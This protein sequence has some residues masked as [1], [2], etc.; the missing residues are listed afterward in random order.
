MARVKFEH[1]SKH[2]GTNT[3]L[4]DISLSV[5][6]GE[7]LVLV[8]P[9]GCGKS[10]MLRMLA[11]LEETVE[12]AISIGDKM[13]NGFPPRERGIAMVF[14]DYA[15]YPHMTVEENMSF[16]LRLRNMKKSEIDERVM[17]AADILRIKPL[18]ARTPKQL[19]GGQRQR[20]AIGR[21]IVRK[22]EV[23]LFDEPLSNLDAKLREEMRVEIT[24]LHQRLKTTIIYVTHDQVEAMTMADRI[25][26]LDKGHVQQVGAP[27]EIYSRPVNTFV[28]GFIGSPAMNFIDGVLE[29]TGLGLTFSSDSAR[30]ALQLSNSCVHIAS[31][32]K[33]PVVLGVRP[34]SIYLQNAAPHARV[35]VE[36]VELLGHRKY[37][38]L[39]AGEQDILASVPASCPLKHGET[40]NISFELSDIHLFDKNTGN[41]L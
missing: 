22:P 4:N 13:V 14:Q 9:S 11:G 39:R 25:A 36:V 38:H 6:D 30:I 1:I 15:L 32:E 5:A 37:L 29:E 23:F 26:V 24:A 28:A 35:V 34:E 19:S 2:F 3:V 16:G 27:E 18:L 21:A 7:F 41:R 12:G 20:V 31:G 8:G 40:A 10:T 33:I 17:Q